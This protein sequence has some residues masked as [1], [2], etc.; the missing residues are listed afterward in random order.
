MT[1]ISSADH[2]YTLR[3]RSGLAQ[4]TGEA[5]EP[6]GARDQYA[7]LIPDLER[8]LGPDH[9]NTQADSRAL[10]RWSQEAN[11]PKC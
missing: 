11:N 3:I 2:P 1:E 9:P 4:W 10:F 8:V 6:G 7:A 5:G